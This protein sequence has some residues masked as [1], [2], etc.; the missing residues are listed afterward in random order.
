M[1]DE[2]VEQVVTEEA[3]Q[4]P[5]VTPKT[6]TQD[7]VNALNAKTKEA[8]R[9]ALLKELGVEDTKSVKDA[10]KRI[11]EQEEAQKTETE[12]L[13]D[14]IKAEQEK[15]S[16]AEQRAT[17]A[18]AQLEAIKSGVPAEKADKLVKLALTY[19]GETI[20]D[21]IKAALE[22]FPE[23]KG[24]PTLDKFG[25]PVKNADKP[26]SSKVEDEFLKAMG[27]GN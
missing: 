16:T 8:E 23:F 22:Q 14:A 2:V 1:E 26:S 7:E 21:K 13:Q 17:I 5:E 24:G 12:K 15:V 11:K 20:A 9:K 27:F 25:Q 4:E 18:E 6:F 19:D 10:L 3:K